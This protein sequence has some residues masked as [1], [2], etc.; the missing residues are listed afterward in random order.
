MAWYETIKYD[1]TVKQPKYWPSKTS[2]LLEWVPNT[3]ISAS[4]ACVF[5]GASCSALKGP[6]EV[7]E[8][9]WKNYVV[10]KVKKKKKKG[11]KT[12]FVI[13]CWSL[14]SETVG[15]TAEKKKKER[16]RKKRL[17]TSIVDSKVLCA[18]LQRNPS[19]PLSGLN[20]IVHCQLNSRW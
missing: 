11:S 15:V 7:E 20:W 9:G 6:K 17:K 5:L 4:I 10:H 13:V 8:Y 12:N 3:I 1:P 14:R 16:K 19:P 18:T 2:L